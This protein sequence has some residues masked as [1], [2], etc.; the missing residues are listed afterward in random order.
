MPSKDGASAPE[1]G[2]TAG[3]GAKENPDGNL[4]L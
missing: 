2:K 3:K 4:A 1:E